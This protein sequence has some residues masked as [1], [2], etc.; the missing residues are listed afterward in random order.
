MLD[1]SV[2]CVMLGGQVSSDV[3]ITPLCVNVLRVKKE[4]RLIRSIEPA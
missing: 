2:A 4:V 3:Y 1:V